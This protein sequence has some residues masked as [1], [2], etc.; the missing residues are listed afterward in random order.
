MGLR[1]AAWPLIVLTVNETSL[2]PVR[3]DVIV[4]AVHHSTF[5]GMDTC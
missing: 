1:K 5:L 4:Q 3:C 2:L